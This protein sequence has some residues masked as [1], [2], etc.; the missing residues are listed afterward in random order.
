[1]QGPLLFIRAG[2]KKLLNI[3][4]RVSCNSAKLSLV[5]G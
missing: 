5:A 1:M 2:G 4:L 3:K